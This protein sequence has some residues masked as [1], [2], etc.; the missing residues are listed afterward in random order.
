MKTLAKKPVAALA[1]LAMLA[2]VGVA[3]AD[4]A[5]SSNLSVTLGLKAWNNEWQTWN[6]P[7][8]TFN[9]SGWFGTASATSLNPSLTLKYGNAF[10][11]GGYMA[12]TT[13]N[14]PDTN[15]AVTSTA[16]RKEND[17]SIGYYIHP[18]VAVT[19]GYKQITQSWGAL[20]FVWKVP[21]VGVSVASPVQ[22]TNFF[23]YG[24]AAVGNASIS[25]PSSAFWTQ[26]KLSGGTY[27][28]SEVG[29]GYSI[30]PK[31]RLTGGYK[32]Q[33]LPTSTEVLNN[34]KR[35]TLVDATRGFVFGGSFTF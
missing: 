13:Y 21:A 34:T 1:L 33:T 17:I 20:E 14:V 35:V 5:A 29:L 19:L 3:H 30:T 15:S 26:W 11:S 27:T 25:H 31:F 9:S 2:G 6:D 18:Q 22:G 7:F 16:K 23:M 4:E 24:N 28:T 12:S 10:I 32:F 8:N